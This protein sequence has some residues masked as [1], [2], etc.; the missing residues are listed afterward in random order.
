MKNK[1]TFLKSNIEIEYDSQEETPT[2][3]EIADTQ[4][5][6][7]KAGCR[8]GYCK[9]CEVKLSKG[10]VKYLCDPPENLEENSILPCIASPQGDIEIQY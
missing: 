6:P 8:S 9:T 3:L 7:L 1:I 10:S 4:G 5:L 2:I